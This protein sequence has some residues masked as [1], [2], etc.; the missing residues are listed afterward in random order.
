MNKT[1]L[2]DEDGERIDEYVLLTIAT[3]GQVVPIAYIRVNVT[4]WNCTKVEYNLVWNL[5]MG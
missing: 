2:V 5:S 4:C 1:Y 3:A